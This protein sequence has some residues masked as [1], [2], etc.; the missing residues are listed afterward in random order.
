MTM[1]AIHGGTVVP[2]EGSPIPG[3][4]VLIDDDRIVAVGAQVR[5]R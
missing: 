3:G 4:T 1:L 2:I 5:T